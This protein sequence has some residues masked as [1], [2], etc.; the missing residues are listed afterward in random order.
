MPLLYPTPV[1]PLGVMSYNARYAVLN[2]SVLVWGVWYKY[3]KIHNHLMDN[4][5]IVVS[6]ADKQWYSLTEEQLEKLVGQGTYQEA[7]VAWDRV[8]AI[9]EAGGKPKVFY[10]EFNGFNVFDD[11]DIESMQRLIFIENRSKRFSS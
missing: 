1:F 6:K 11:N 10:S 4:K 2:S 7:P 9:R 5:K 8:S 3:K